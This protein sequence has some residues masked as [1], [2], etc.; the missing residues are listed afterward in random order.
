MKRFLLFSI[1]IGV[2]LATL[3]EAGEI[4]GRV[5]DTMGPML[6]LECSGRIHNLD[7]IRAKR[8]VVAAWAAGLARESEQKRARQKARRDG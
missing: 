8:A 4:R 7:L 3:A 2:G 5:T 6:C 1:V